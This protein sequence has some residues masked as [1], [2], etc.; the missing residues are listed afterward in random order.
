[1]NEF[2]QLSDMTLVNTILG[3]NFP[4]LSQQWPRGFTL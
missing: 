4:G 3:T 1:M 2:R